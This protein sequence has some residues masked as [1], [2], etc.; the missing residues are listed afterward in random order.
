MNRNAKID[1]GLLGCDLDSVINHVLP[2]DSHRIRPSQ[3]RIEQNLEGE[4]LRRPLA[5]MLA[6][7]GNVRLAPRAIPF[8]LAAHALRILDR[9]LS[10]QTSTNGI[11][12]K[13]VQT[14]TQMHRCARRQPI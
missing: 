13:L 12:E 10:R 2:T 1:A 8:R 9:V 3:P 11:F 7:C 4:P 14:L 6:K 5:P